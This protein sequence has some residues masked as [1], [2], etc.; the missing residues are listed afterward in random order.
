MADMI[1]IKRILVLRDLNIMSE[2]WTE[3]KSERVI[4]KSRDDLVKNWMS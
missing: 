2:L 1:Y 4:E 3:R